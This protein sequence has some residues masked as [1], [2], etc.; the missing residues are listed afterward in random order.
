MLPAVLQSDVASVATAAFTHETE[1]ALACVLVLQ[2]AGVA[3]EPA[4][5]GFLTFPP[6]GGRQP[7]RS[8]AQLAH[9]HCRGVSRHYSGCS[10]VSGMEVGIAMR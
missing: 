7:I 6:V 8:S 5:A 3:L 10:C 1:P 2:R 4:L 9:C